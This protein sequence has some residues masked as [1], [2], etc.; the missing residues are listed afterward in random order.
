VYKVSYL[1]SATGKYYAYVPG[2]SSPDK[3][4]VISS[5][6]AYFVVTNAIGTL[7]LGT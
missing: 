3:D 1:D 2:V 6:R 7:G 4:F 5:G